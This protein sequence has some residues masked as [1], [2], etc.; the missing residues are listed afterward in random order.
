MEIKKQWIVMTG[1][2]LKQLVLTMQDGY[3]I[4]SEGSYKSM[5]NFEARNLILT[6]SQGA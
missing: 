2:K 4:E 6:T 1:G 3:Y 5:G